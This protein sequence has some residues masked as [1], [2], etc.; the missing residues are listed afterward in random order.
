MK[1]QYFLDFPDDSLMKN[2][3]MVDGKLHNRPSYYAFKDHGSKVYWMIPFSSKLIKF[4]N[5][6]NKKI[7][8]NGICD[9]IA[10]GFVMGEKKAFLIQNMCPVTEEYIENEYI[11]KATGQAV[12]VSESLQHELNTKAAKVLSLL[13]KGRNLIFPD[14]IA[15]EKVLLEK[16]KSVD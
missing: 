14:V 16:M 1:D 11:D 3:E 13:R 6:F 9:T 7:A 5:E 8:K 4:E 2:R 12:Q 15:I 10:F